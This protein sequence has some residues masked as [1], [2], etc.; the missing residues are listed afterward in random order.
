MSIEEQ[1]RTLAAELREWRST[2]ASSFT[3]V[4]AAPPPSA[5]DQ[6]ELRVASAARANGGTACISCERHR[7]EERV[8]REELGRARAEADAAGGER[9]EL[10]GRLGEYQAW[11]QEQDAWVEQEVHAP[12]ALSQS[13]WAHQFGELGCFPNAK[14]TDLYRKARIST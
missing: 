14:L 1:T 5:A 6:A 11:E 8:L 13:I 2:G 7:E 12:P 3:S 10:R 9:D 4:P